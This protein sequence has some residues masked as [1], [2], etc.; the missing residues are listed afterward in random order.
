MPSL[1]TS[2]ACSSVLQSAICLDLVGFLIKM[3]SFLNDG[4]TLFPF[5]GD[6]LENLEPGRDLLKLPALRFNPE[7]VHAGEEDKVIRTI[8]HIELPSKVFHVRSP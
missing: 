6:N 2:I 5:N 1:L 7:E 8:D 4:S 3:R